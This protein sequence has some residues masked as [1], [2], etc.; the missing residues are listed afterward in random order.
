MTG[1]ISI[2]RSIEQHWLYEETRKFSRF[3]AWIDML[4]MVNHSDNK[5]VHDGKL[6]T[7]K[8][9]QRIT[10][11]RQ[12]SERWSWSTTK[13]DAFLKLLESDGMIEVK[14]DTKKTLLTIVNYDFY[15]SD[16]GRKKHINDTEKIQNKNKNDS[17]QNQKKTN[18]NDNNVNNENNVVVSDSDNTFKTILNLYQENIEMTPSQITLQKIGQDFDDYGYELMKHAIEKSALA[19][20]HDYRFIAY[21]LKDW[22]KNQL[23]TVEAVKQYEAQREAKKNYSNNRGQTA[24]VSPYANMEFIEPDEDDLPF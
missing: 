5:T 6:V 3:E 22:N 4:L 10:S 2:H 16:E 7:V 21:L 12:L 19:N 1:W 9:G 14:K 24:T 8:R 13:V 18:N 11:L 23:R 15:Q 17:N 20:N